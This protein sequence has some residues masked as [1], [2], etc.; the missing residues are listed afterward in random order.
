MRNHRIPARRLYQNK[1]KR[2]REWGEPGTFAQLM[3]IQNDPAIMTTEN[4]Q[5]TREI[6]FRGFPQK[7]QRQHDEETLA[8]VD[9]MRKYPRN[10][11]W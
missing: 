3:G 1:N 9:Q 6:F 8:L 11:L 7:T 5:V 2:W 4:Y 10:P